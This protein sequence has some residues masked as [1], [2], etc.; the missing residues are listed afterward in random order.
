MAVD[1]AI[2]SN[3]VPNPP[4]SL[5]IQ[6]FRASSVVLPVYGRITANRGRKHGGPRNI[7][8][9]CGQATKLERVCP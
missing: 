4:V 7:Q 8:R 2:S 1:A 3:P 5:E 9:C 6:A